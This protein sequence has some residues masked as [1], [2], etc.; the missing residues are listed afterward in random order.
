MH[1]GIDAPT[2]AMRRIEVMDNATDDAPMLPCLL[3]QI[4]ASEGI[5]SVSGDGAYDT[6]SCNEAI[7]LRGG[8]AII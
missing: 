7:A 8:Q 4:D 3:D 6:K 5:A 2:M 1:L